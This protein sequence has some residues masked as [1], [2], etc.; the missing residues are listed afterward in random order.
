MDKSYFRK[1]KDYLSQMYH[2][3]LKTSTGEKYRVLDRHWANFGWGRLPNG[4][5][6]FH[7]HEVWLCTCKGNSMGEWYKETPVVVVF[8]KNV[9]RD[10]SRPNRWMPIVP[11]IAAK[12][13]AFKPL[14]HPD[15]EAYDAPLPM[16][17]T[18]N[19]TCGS[20]RPTS[21]G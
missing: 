21:G 15:F 6:K 9:K 12:G 11:W 17:V 18:S 5:R 16:E 10:G 14:T 8:A 19:R 2:A 20:Y 1:W 7:P 3:N 13:H 4:Q